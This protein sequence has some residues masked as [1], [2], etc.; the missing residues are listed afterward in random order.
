MFSMI[1]FQLSGLVIVLFITWLHFTRRTK[2]IITERIFEVF[3]LLV[4]S[5]LLLDISS[6][7]AIAHR[8]KFPFV[9]D[10]IAKL[11]LINLIIIALMTLVYLLADLFLHDKKMRKRFR[12]IFVLL[13]VILC[14]YFFLPIYYF[15]DLQNQVVYS[16][17]PAVL[18]TYICSLSFLTLSL[19]MLILFRSKVS[20]ARKQPVVVI[21]LSFMIS[22]LI[23]FRHNELLLV[24]FAMSAA[25]MIIYLFIENPY[26]RTDMELGINNE[27]AW[28]LYITQMFV[29]SKPFN[30][31]SFYINDLDSIT[32][33]F[34]NS[35]K[36]DLLLSI[37]DFLHTIDN[38]IC[39]RMEA[40]NFII[41]SSQI[42]NKELLEKISSRFT[43]PFSVADANIKLS[44]S[45]CTYPDS[46]LFSDAQDLIRIK[47]YIHL[48]TKRN[49]GKTFITVDKKLIEQHKEIVNVKK[50]L[51]W[52][53]ENDGF[54]VYYQPIYSFEK[55]K[56]V[57][58]EALTRLK[59]EVGNFINPETFIRIAEENGL[60]LEIGMKVFEKVCK[61]IKDFHPEDLG[62]EFIEVNLSVVQ[63]M[64][65]SLA[66]DLMAIMDKY[67]ID[68]G[69]INFEITET[70]M[71]NSKEV[72]LENMSQLIEK[73]S[74]FYLDDYGSG[75]SNLSYIIGLPLHAV[76]LDKSIV[77]ASFDSEKGNIAL[78]FA[79]RMIKSLNMAIV[80]E[81]IENVEQLN[82]MKELNVDLI[83]G[84][85]FSCPVEPKQFVKFMFEYNDRS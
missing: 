66:G 59:D 60:I 22:A 58:A 85:Y 25:V 4:L 47:N 79:V 53:L 21:I 32:D 40:N 73:S 13:A 3:L 83:Q 42:K 31:V 56:I 65:E 2:W 70:T 6:V 14:S 17:G 52:A 48:Q 18:M 8:D 68:P 62:I 46:S 63:C 38:S 49:P 9:T 36:T 72:L 1:Q 57:S 33:I 82:R 54:D 76:K 81:G 74:N 5:G 30:M 51:Q 84:Y 80:A 61:F 34:G 29:R 64:Q 69:F 10:L 12:I 55:D 75:Y 7:F 43:E 45:Y 23:Q 41:V 27:H 16:Y 28:T 35:N 39:F 44:V 15:F 71:L 20:F 11:Y 26:L 37:T 19:V 78:E 50:R 67:E 77:W 24:G